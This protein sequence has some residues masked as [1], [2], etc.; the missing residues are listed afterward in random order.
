MTEKTGM[1]NTISGNYNDLDEN[2]T[3]PAMHTSGTNGQ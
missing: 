1:E 2:Y 3:G